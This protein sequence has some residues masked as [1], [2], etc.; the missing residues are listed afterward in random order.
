M[1][2]VPPGLFGQGAGGI[3]RF[4]RPADKSFHRPTGHGKAFSW[5]HVYRRQCV[6]MSTPPANPATAL[7][8]AAGTKALALQA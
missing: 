6:M 2:R 3:L 1:L 7:F 5:L 8:A 4:H